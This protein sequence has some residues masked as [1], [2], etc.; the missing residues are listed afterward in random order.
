MFNN[1]V[2]WFGRVE[3]NR[4]P[5]K[6]GKVQVR[7]FGVHNKLPD[8]ELPWIPVL[9]APIFGGTSE[10]TCPPPALQKNT[11]VL[12]L[13]IDGPMMQQNLVYGICTNKA[14]VDEMAQNGYGMNLAG[15]AGG[16][17]NSGNYGGSAQVTSRDLS[18]DA[19]TEINKL[20]E[21]MG[22]EPEMLRAI[23]QVE[24]SAAPLGPDGRPTIRF[25]AHVFYDELRKKYSDAE[26]AKIMAD[27]NSSNFNGQSLINTA[28]GKER[29]KLNSISNAQSERW[30]LYEYA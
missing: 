22:V 6:A 27:Y 4:D 19:D 20:A 29:Y 14:V 3:N 7:I 16:N 21:E 5:D 25:E 28:S 30:D 23:I 8:S 13:A 18:A 26:I 1:A 10:A 12:G 11:N 24:T 15:Y 9:M 2:W 17:V